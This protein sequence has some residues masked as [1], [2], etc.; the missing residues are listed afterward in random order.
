[1]NLFVPLGGT[2]RPRPALVYTIANGP[3]KMNFWVRS[4]QPVSDRLLENGLSGRLGARNEVLEHRNG[5]ESLGH[6]L[7][8]CRLV[9]DRAGAV[10]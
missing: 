2:P 1:M 5:K 4:S 6:K 10:R 7:L 9:S 3:A 8:P